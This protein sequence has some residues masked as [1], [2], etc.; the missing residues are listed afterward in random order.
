MVYSGPVKSFGFKRLKL[1]KK[2]FKLHVLLND[3]REVAASKSVPH[4]G[5]GTR[6]Y[7]YI[8]NIYVHIHNDIT[9]TE[10]I[11]YDLYIYVE[12]CL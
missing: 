4:R 6:Q 7:I 12:I 9:C 1:L 2:K 5:M 10:Y 8:Y 3:E 11:F